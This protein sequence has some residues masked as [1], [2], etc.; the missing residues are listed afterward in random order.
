MA[1][2]RGGRDV[3]VNWP[4]WN[5]QGEGEGHSSPSLKLWHFARYK[6][7]FDHKKSLL[8]LPP[9]LILVFRGRDEKNLGTLRVP[10]SS[11]LFKA[12]PIDLFFNVS[13]LY[14]WWIFSILYKYC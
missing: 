7:I 9:P 3:R 8:S 6:N 2:L 5:F 11:P 13:K 1:D 14:E 4:K 12:V 10:F